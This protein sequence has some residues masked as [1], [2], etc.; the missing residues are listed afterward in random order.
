ML[1]FTGYVPPI[2]PQGLADHERREWLVQRMDEIDA[3][4][5]ELVAQRQTELRKAP[6]ARRTD[7]VDWERRLLVTV[8]A[9]KGERGEVRTLLSE[10]N[11][12]IK[13]AR[14]KLHGA[15]LKDHSVATAFHFIACQH[16]N[17]ETLADWEAQA[18]AMVERASEKNHP[19][20]GR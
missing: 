8:N 16:L 2:I 18:L 10:T 7:L 17:E 1:D 3:G 20:P 15:S 11:A 14:R 12:R 6:S 4:C 9:L 19:K 13:D 5:R